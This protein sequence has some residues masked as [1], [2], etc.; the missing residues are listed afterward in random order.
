M[1]EIQRENV[2]RLLMY[3]MR[4]KPYTEMDED[5]LT[6]KFKYTS[7]V[8]ASALGYWSYVDPYIWY[9]YDAAIVKICLAESPNVKLSIHVNSFP[10]G[11]NKP[12]ENKYSWQPP[13]HTFEMVSQESKH[14]D[15]SEVC[16][17]TNNLYVDIF[18]KLNR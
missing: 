4:E 13:Y 18:K 5:T 3:P 17:G 10:Y 7:D 2:D 15:L 12:S 11:D 14:P 9:T 16:A 1:S 8:L 6:I